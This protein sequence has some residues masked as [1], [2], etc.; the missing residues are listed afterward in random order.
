MKKG[1][2]QVSEDQRLVGING[3]F[4][5]HAHNRDPYFDFM[6]AFAEQAD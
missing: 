4:L 3:D 1:H 6:H 2:E 5:S